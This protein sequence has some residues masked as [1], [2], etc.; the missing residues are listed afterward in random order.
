MLTWI[1]A[2][3]DVGAGFTQVTSHAP[4][5]GFGSRLCENTVND[6]ILRRFGR[7]IR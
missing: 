4:D 2:G 6:M 5:V 3:C 7:R 1:N